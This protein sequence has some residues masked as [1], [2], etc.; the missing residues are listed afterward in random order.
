M[1]SR[2]ASTPALMRRRG[3]P[4][5]SRGGN[6]AVRG[7]ALQRVD[8][9]AGKCCTGEAFV[10][11]VSVDDPGGARCR[12]SRLRLRESAGPARRRRRRGRTDSRS[13]RRRR[14]AVSAVAG[15]HVEDVGRRDGFDRDARRDDGARAEPVTGQRGGRRQAE[16]RS[17]R[18]RAH[19]APPGRCAARR[20][21]RSAPAQLVRPACDDLPRDRRPRRASPGCASRRSG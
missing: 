3:R 16:A 12:S 13:S 9:P 19:A 5:P 21:A 8:D 4:L 7:R 11:P 2:Q 1:A 15:R 14:G 18:R 17:S 10:P 6:P 20:S